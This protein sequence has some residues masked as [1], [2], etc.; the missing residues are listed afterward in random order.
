MSKS[1][2]KDPKSTNANST[3]SSAEKS[4]TAVKLVLIFFISLLSFSVGT[5]VGKQVSDSDTRRA[6]LEVDYN[7]GE[8]T[9]AVQATPSEEDA[10]TAPI[11]D[12]DV[13]SLSKEFMDKTRDV[14]SE[15]ANH[16]TAGETGESEASKT[17]EHST[18]SEEAS[19]EEHAETPASEK[20]GYTHHSKL[21]ASS[22]E[23][24]ITATDK[25]IKSE[26][27]TAT[28][29]KIATK[30]KVAPAAERVAHNLA[31]AAD[32]KENHAPSTALPDVASTAVGKY[33]VQVAS[34][35]TEPEA[36]AHA[37]KLNG[38]GYEAFYIPATIN[39]KTWYRVSVGL[40]L[41]SKSASK[42]R[43]ELLA[44]QAVSTA[45]VSKIIK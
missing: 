39:N 29:E 9:A 13:A 7:G 14:A 24:A 12:E 25:T 11:A 26:L 2:I 1:E 23:A 27:K 30:A 36:K 45:I 10:D 41:D 20:E 4:D 38:K 35:A 40:F 8:K 34:F 42:Y 32:P 21:S 28:H 18:S 31:P 19:S 3:A 5:Y 16:E 44:S 33:T 15:K 37:A 6:A 22:H 17:S 43:S